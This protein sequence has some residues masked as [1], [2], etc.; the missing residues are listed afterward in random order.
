M[1]E[2]QPCIVCGRIT[3]QGCTSLTYDNGDLKIVVNGVP[4]AICEQCGEE[5]VPGEFGV[6]LG[7]RIPEIV[8]EIRAR[9]RV[10]HGP[11]Q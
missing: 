3:R 8:E 1:Y 5:Y 6:W 2:V 9:E 11:D 10:D 4:A 7:D